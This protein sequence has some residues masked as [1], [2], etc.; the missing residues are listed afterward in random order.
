MCCLA[1]HHMVQSGQGGLRGESCPERVRPWLAPHRIALLAAWVAVSVSIL[2]MLLADVRS[3]E[4]Y[5]VGRYV[6]HAGYVAILLWHLSR[7][8]APPERLPRLEP[9]LRLP[10][11]LGLWVPV[12]GVVLILWLCAVSDDG[13]DLLMLLLIAATAW[14]LLAWRRE[15][16]PRAVLQGLAVAL[17]AFLAGLPLAGSGFVGETATWLLPLFSAPMYVAGGLLLDRTR[18]GGVQLLAGRYGETARSLLAGCVLFV[19]LG[20][21]NAAEG[22]PGAGISWVNQ[23]WMPLTLPLFSGITEETWFRLLL[24][25]LSYFFVR[26]AFRTHPALAVVIAVLFSGV[27]FGLGHG[28][29]LERFLT[30]GL[31]YGVPLA[32][33]FARRDWEHAVGAHYMVNMIPWWSVFFE[34]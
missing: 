11:R 6:L 3:S 31:L 20:L 32:A 15:I 33:V 10:W 30:T 12:P 34:T 27:T 7:S 5:E 26:P 17:I 13:F 23:W 28:R 25:G 22:S 18:L 29:T 1:V 21:A 2:S 8:G 9:Q 16:R 4:R 24:V 14:I 19:P